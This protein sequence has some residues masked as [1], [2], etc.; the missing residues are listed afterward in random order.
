MKKLTSHLNYFF[1]IVVIAL[2][3]ANVSSLAQ[4]SG[5]GTESNPY[6]IS[7]R[8]LFDTLVKYIENGDD[9]AKKHFKMTTNIGSASAPWTKII[10]VFTGGTISPN[11]SSY[12]F[13]GHLD[14]NNMRIYLK[15][16]KTPTTDSRP[17]G[18]FSKI[19]NGSVKNLIVLGSVSSN[20]IAGGIVG[21]MRDATLDGCLNL[22]TISGSNNVGGIVGEFYNRNR[23]ANIINCRDSGSVTGEYCVG[24]IAGIIKTVGNASGLT[25]TVRGCINFGTI[26]NTSAADY[27]GGI[28]GMSESGQM[29]NISG[30][31]NL[32]KIG[33]ISCRCVGGIV[34]AGV[35][36]IEQSL[37]LGVVIGNTQVGGIIGGGNSGFIEYSMNA[38]VVNSVNAGGIMGGIFPIPPTEMINWTAPPKSYIGYCLNV[39]TV[40]S[41]SGGAILGGLDD[42]AT[43]AHCYYDKQLTMLPGIRNRGDVVNSAEGKFTQE[44]VGTALQSVFGTAWTYA[45]DKYPTIALL[46]SNNYGV[47]AS[48]PI[49]L[50]A[51]SN[52]LTINKHFKVGKT[53]NVSWNTHFK[54]IMFDGESATITDIGLDTINCVRSDARKRIPINIVGAPAYMSHN[55]DVEAWPP[56][57][58]EVTGGG[59]YDDSTFAIIEAVPNEHYRFINWEVL[60]FGVHFSTLASDTVLIN[61]SCTFRAHFYIDSF[62]LDLTPEP[63]NMGNIVGVGSYPYGYNVKYWATPNYGYHFVKWTDENGDLLTE[64]IAGDIDM[65]IDRHFTAHFEI[66]TFKIKLS[67]DPPLYGTASVN[68]EDS[69]KYVYLTPLQIHTRGYD[70]CNHLVKWTAFG[71]TT[72]IS[73]DPNFIL[74]LTSDTHIVAHYTETKRVVTLKASIPEAVSELKGAGEFPCVPFAI[75]DIDFTA[76]DPVKYKFI[77]WIDS[78]TGN[79]I[80]PNKN[81]KLEV[82]R[83]Y[84]LIAD[85]IE[86]ITPVC[87]INLLSNPEEGGMAVTSDGASVYDTNSDVT[88][89][90]TPNDDLG[91]RFVNWRTTDGVVISNSKTYSFTISQDTILVAHFSNNYTLSTSVSD[92]SMGSI[93]G[94]TSGMYSYNTSISLTAVVSND[95]LYKFVHWTDG[96]GHIL[97]TAETIDFILKSDTSIIA[98]FNIVEYIEDLSSLTTFN[99][100]P[101]PASTHF[102]MSL[103]LLEVADVKIS[104]LDMS[105]REIM[106][107]TEGVHSQGLW[108]KEVDISK[109]PSAT[110]FLSIRVG[111]DNYGG[112]VMIQR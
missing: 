11:D 8:A 108:N 101:N 24:G 66:D 28:C 2:L 111:K 69:G 57:G 47:V 18:L 29:N 30:C 103:E 71:D 91:Y 87:I 76:I 19:V 55:I 5:S 37:N 31:V 86:I 15:I 106:I 75:T 21:S 52:R 70:T 109:I 38:G 12:V 33:N 25:L 68:G 94:H 84:T 32:G 90:A 67:V 78:A 104:L 27:I 62:K 46:A 23:S 7:S 105:G 14:G 4:F 95:S 89:E 63:Q 56:Q 49:F 35:S 43:V 82:A 85:F 99:I 65:V 13:Q 88:I 17:A 45:T 112:K 107:I 80:S 41:E 110:Y 73:T 102:I 51:N 50:D 48:T 34:G 64:N 22:A 92:I 44:L 79:V 74:T 39:G 53:T 42:A 54:R 59:M 96:A 20:D 26:N 93:T 10:G 40:E 3:T 9:I 36:S 97:D 1:A 81:F 98:I 6:L 72:T 77:N 16:D 83:N 100:S 61:M 60:P 58:G